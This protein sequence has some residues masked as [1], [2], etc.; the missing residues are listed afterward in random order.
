MKKVV[1]LG[2]SGLLGSALTRYLNNQNIYQVITISYHSPGTDFQA[3]MSCTSRAVELLSQVSPDIIINLAA[4]TN[5]D[6]CERERNLAY[7]VNCKIVENVSL[8]NNLLKK[9]DRPFI[10]QISTDHFYEGGT[11]SK[12]SDVVILNNYAMTKYCGEKSLNCH[13]SVVLRTNFLGKSL[14]A[15]S[16]SL[17]DQIYARYQ[18]G[19]EVCLFNDV[20]ISALSIDTLCEV[21]SLCLVEQIPGIYNVGSKQGLSK[22]VAIVTFFE[23]LGCKNFKYKSV[24]IDSLNLP[25]RRPKD[26]RMDVSAFEQAYQ[27]SLPNFKNEIRKIANEYK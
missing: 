16:M 3:D 15:S 20:F 21:I 13:E 2:A 5:L 8:Y 14:V 23:Y 24:S 26:M 17:T 1:I 18:S 25:T 6:L 7:L 9:R 27:Y 10:V 11:E 12:E 22:E 4:I 19:E